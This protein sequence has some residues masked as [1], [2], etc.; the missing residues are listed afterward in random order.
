MGLK[1]LALFVGFAIL[2]WGIVVYQVRSARHQT[3]PP[4][5][6]IVSLPAQAAG[7]AAVP[8]PATPIAP[9][10]PL[11]EVAQ[12]VSTSEAVQIP[13]KGWG[14]NPFLT[15]EEIAKLHEPAKPAEPAPVEPQRTVLPN[16]V[17]SAIVI[18]GKGF[19]RAVID[20]RILKVG[21]RIG[22]ETV[23]EITPEA[24]VLEAEGKTRKI[25][26]MSG[27]MPERTGPKG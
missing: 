24:I 7:P 16:Y 15:L 1:K 8:P 18:D 19:S 5:Q 22:M 27:S 26:L 2:I 3:S 21:D 25:Q 20:S 10:E 9:V 6:A 14:R 12:P 23:K 4:S 17:L 13:K 11:G